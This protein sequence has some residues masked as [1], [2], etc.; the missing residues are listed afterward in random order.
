MEIVNLGNVTFLSRGLWIPIKKHLMACQVSSEVL[1]SGVIVG[2]SIVPCWFRAR[3]RFRWT[4]VG[5]IR[6]IRRTSW[7][8]VLRGP[9][10]RGGRIFRRGVRLYVL[11]RAAV[12]PFSA[13]CRGYVLKAATVIIRSRWYSRTRRGWLRAIRGWVMVRRL[14]TTI[15]LKRSSRWARNWGEGRV[16]VIRVIA[17]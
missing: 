8:F 3:I 5:Q 16:W 12:P 17:I 9:R 14:S 11:P 1:I 10:S 6:L 13:L 4:T 15:L 2:W 7:R